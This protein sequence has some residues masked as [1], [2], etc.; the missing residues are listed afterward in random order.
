MN[1]ASVLQERY[2]TAN[3]V[4]Y[5]AFIELCRQF[6][7]EPQKAATQDHHI[8]P[9]KQFPELEHEP[10]NLITLYTPL[11]MHA[12]ELLHAAVPELWARSK[13]IAG[14]SEGGRLGGLKSVELRIGVHARSPEK[15]A[16]D[17]RKA[18]RKNV[19]SGHL[20]RLRTHEHQ[21]AAARAGGKIGG[22][23]KSAAKTAARRKC[24]ENGTGIFAL[25]IAAKAGRKSAPL[26]NHTRWHVNR[27]IVNPACELCSYSETLVSQN[28]GLPFAHRE[29]LC[30]QNSD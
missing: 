17:S 7:P 16:E 9:R 22:K 26:N 10:E 21:V 28:T 25:G 13:W 24:K 8:C 2:P 12:H 14:A 6:E 4:V 5:S 29:L 23:V 3:L 27:G 11:H 1:P 19:E 30:R 20:A 15:R 18:G